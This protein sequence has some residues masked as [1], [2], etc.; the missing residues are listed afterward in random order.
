[1]NKLVRFYKFVVIWMQEVRELY[2]AKHP[3]Y[4]SSDRILG[5]TVSQ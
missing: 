5:R 2:K 1:M 4:Q 3:K